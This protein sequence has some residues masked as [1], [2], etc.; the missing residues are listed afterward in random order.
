MGKYYLIVVVSVVTGVTAVWG[1]WTGGVCIFVH[2]FL[3]ETNAI[4][5][6]IVVI[7]TFFIF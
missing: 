4:E 1:A 6:K 7:R 5:A 2:S 3:H